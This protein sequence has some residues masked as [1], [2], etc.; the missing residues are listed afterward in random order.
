MQRSCGPGR[1]ASK[2]SENNMDLAVCLR[3]VLEK[4]P[5]G[6]DFGLQ[7]G[8]GNTYDTIQKQRSRGEDL[9][10]KCIVIARDNRKDGLPNFVGSLAQG[11]VTGRFLYI[12]V[13]QYAGQ[14]DSCWS[15]RIK[16]PLAGITWDL[17]QKAFADPH[18]ALE[19][20]LPGTGKDGEPSCGT[21]RSP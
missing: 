13:G 19:V 17:I 18:A 4:P 10:F 3:I 8:K 6:V 21:V 14:T 1:K 12:D 20:R 11:P 16:V 9:C 5:S 15:R 7:E 2:G